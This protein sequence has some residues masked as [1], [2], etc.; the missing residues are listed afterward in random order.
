[1]TPPELPYGRRFADQSESDSWPAWQNAVLQDLADL[2][3]GQKET[4]EL[5]IKLMIDQATQK[6]K[7]AAI[8]GIAALIVTAVAHMLI[9]SFKDGK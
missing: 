6:G 9:T 3:K 5:V 4:N 8:G 2:K 7:M 1:M